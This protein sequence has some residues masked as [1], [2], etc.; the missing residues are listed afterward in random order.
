MAVFKNF[1]GDELFISCKCGCDEG[2]HFKIMIME[3]V[4]MLSC[5]IQMGISTLSKDHSLRN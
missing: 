2:I 5:H 1:K 3:M 4:I